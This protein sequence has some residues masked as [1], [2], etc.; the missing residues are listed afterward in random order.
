MHFL[1]QSRKSESGSDVIN[2]LNSGGS[3]SASVSN[4]QRS[5][6]RKFLDNRGVR[7]SSSSTTSKPDCYRCIV[8]LMSYGS[9]ISC[10]HHNEDPVENGIVSVPP[11][12]IKLI[13]CTPD[14]ASSGDTEDINCTRK[15]KN[16]NIIN[17][18]SVIINRN[19]AVASP[20]NCDSDIEKN[21]LGNNSFSEQ[22]WDSYQEK[23]MSEPYSEAADVETA[24]RL[25]EF[26]DDY[27]NF[28]DS[29]SDCASS[30][31]A[32]RSCSSPIISSGLNYVRNNLFCF[33]LAKLI[34]LST[35]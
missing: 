10:P 11:P 4:N 26:G 17:I 20:I 3:D 14:P 21:S 23:Y 35:D 29:Q 19:D 30:F 6:M 33:L 24:R 15:H 22:A 8:S 18:E 2:A 13:C 5:C 34:N 12:S 1:I 16:D 9:T 28:L 27:R 7:T 25:L 32:V 31:S